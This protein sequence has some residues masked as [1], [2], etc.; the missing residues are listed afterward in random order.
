MHTLGPKN[1]TIPLSLKIPYT[2]YSSLCFGYIIDPVTVPHTA[3]VFTGMYTFF[4]RGDGVLTDFL[5]ARFLL[6]GVDRF[7]FYRN[8]HRRGPGYS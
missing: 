2:V 7:C 1:P 5:G 6:H 3:F 4:G 8:R